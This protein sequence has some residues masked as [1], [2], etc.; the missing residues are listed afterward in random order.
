MHVCTALRFH[1]SMAARR[2]HLHPHQAT[3]V[4]QPWWKK[5]KCTVESVVPA[6][7]RVRI[8][9]TPCSQPALLAVEDVFTA[10]AV[11]HTPQHEG[12]VVVRVEGHAGRCLL[13]HDGQF[14]YSSVS[15]DEIVQKVM[16]Q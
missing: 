6:P 16:D 5:T 12:T 3:L 4:F 9:G 15:F 14:D 2:A 13:D 11:K 8:D 10:L 1:S 7:F